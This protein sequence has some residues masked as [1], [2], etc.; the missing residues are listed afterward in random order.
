MKQ[1]QITFADTTT[2]TGI[3][4]TVST[5]KHARPKI[6]RFDKIIIDRIRGRGIYINFLFIMIH[7][8]DIYFDMTDFEGDVRDTELFERPVINDIFE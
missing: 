5:S 3:Q 7:F 8:T 2:G 1:L 6:S 4:I